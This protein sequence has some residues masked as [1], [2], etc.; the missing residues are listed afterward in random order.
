M[1][2]DTKLE[3]V[4]LSKKGGKTVIV[5]SIDQFI[6]FRD[7]APKKWDKYEGDYVSQSFSAISFRLP[8]TTGETPKEVIVV[9]DGDRTCNI[10]LRA[11]EGV[12]GQ[13]R[14]YARKV[15]SEIPKIDVDTLF[16]TQ[17]SPFLLEGIPII[18][19][20]Y[21]PNCTRIYNMTT[22]GG[23]YSYISA[24]SEESDNR[25][26]EAFIVKLVDGDKSKLLVDLKRSE[27][28]VPKGLEDKIRK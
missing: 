7:S 9:S 15:D 2:S 19:G 14:L 27:S 25:D 8:C 13:E 26:H 6:W 11:D 10:Y 22:H 16:T 17:I 3:S 21:P 28:W 5:H 4:E 20:R 18:K 24:I 23:L 12:N 1:V